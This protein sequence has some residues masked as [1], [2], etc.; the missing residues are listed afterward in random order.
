MV[1]RMLRNDSALIN[2]SLQKRVQLVSPGSHL[3]P[4]WKDTIHYSPANL[5][6]ALQFT[7]I[8]NP[9]RGK[10]P[11]PWQPLL[12]LCPHVMM[13]RVLFSFKVSRVDDK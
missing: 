4:N 3:Y 6:N 8:I 13:K 7:F 12:G 11:R 9:T 5:I 1:C 10:I 2:V